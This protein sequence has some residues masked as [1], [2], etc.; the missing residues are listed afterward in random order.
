MILNFYV[1]II[2]VDDGQADKW[3]AYANKFV[4]QLIDPI[5]EDDIKKKSGFV[6]FCGIVRHLASCELFRKQN[7][8]FI[9]RSFVY[10]V[11]VR[12][13]K[14]MDKAKLNHIKFVLHDMAFLDIKRASAGQSKMGAFILA[15]CFI[16]YLAGFVAGKETTRKDYKAFVKNYLPQLYNPEMLYR[17][18]RC[19]LVHNYSEGGSYMFVYA[20]SDL[21]GNQVAG[22]MVVNLEDFIAGIEVALHK[23]LAELKNDGIKAKKAEGRFDKIGLISIAQ[24]V[25]RK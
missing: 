16:E 15:S 7:G 8:C 9:N 24:H 5:E 17:D 6:L 23:L 3:N 20:K 10:I 11:I 1:C 14:N 21:H 2:Y 25:V 18:L 19:K 12:R 4:I 13:K 22:K